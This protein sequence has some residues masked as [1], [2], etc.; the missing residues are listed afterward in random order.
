M[1]ERGGGG[2]RERN[3]NGWI[4]VNELKKKKKKKKKERRKEKKKKK[5]PER[6]CIINLHTREL[7][8]TRKTW[9]M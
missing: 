7:I 2:E 6:S 8:S 9:R 5:S 1:R 4:H 3:C